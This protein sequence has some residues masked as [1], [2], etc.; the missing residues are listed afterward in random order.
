MLYL[1]PQRAQQLDGL[2]ANA[3]SVAADTK[4]EPQ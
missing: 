4:E 1:T 2:L 3:A